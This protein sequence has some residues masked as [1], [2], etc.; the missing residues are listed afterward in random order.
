MSGRLIISKID[1]KLEILIIYI[2]AYVC[3]INSFLTLPRRIIEEVPRFRIFLIYFF[4][5]YKY[6]L[7]KRRKF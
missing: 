2:N 4:K 3:K 7:N 6:V 5:A 1:L